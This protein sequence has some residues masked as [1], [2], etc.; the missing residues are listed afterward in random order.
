MSKEKKMIEGQLSLFDLFDA[1][2]ET[3]PKSFSVCSEC[4]CRDCRHNAANEGVPREL[5]GSK[6]ACPACDMCVSSGDPQ[7]C[8]IGSAKEGCS[9]RAAEEG[10]EE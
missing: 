6:Q 4:W 7:I 1:N 2:T 3:T 9:V 8:I 5:C 10:I